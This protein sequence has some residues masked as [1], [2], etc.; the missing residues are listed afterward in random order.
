VREKYNDLNV[1]S[2]IVQ[3]M[4]KTVQAPELSLRGEIV[5]LE[6]EE[7]QLTFEPRPEVEWASRRDVSEN[8][9]L[10]EASKPV[11]AEKPSIVPASAVGVSGE[12]ESLPPVVQPDLS[13]MTAI[14]KS[15]QAVARAGKPGKLDIHYVNFVK[16][17]V[18]H[19]L[20]EKADDGRQAAYREAQA[21]LAADAP[22][23]ERLIG[24][25]GAIDRAAS[26][27]SS[28]R[29]VGESLERQEEFCFAKDREAAFKAILA[30]LEANK[31][32]GR[33]GAYS[34]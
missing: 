21:L 12:A 27:Y 30:D 22:D 26:R 20:K 7:R 1:Q 34:R 15:L 17:Y 9:T 8:L 25:I 18:R 14:A 33:A 10:M 11:E 29:K 2:E 13:D 32:N 5:D 19:V 24:R 23:Y 6:R 16:P 31:T 28:T 4:P 3:D